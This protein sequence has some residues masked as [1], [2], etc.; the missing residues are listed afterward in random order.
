LVD[1]YTT[2]EVLDCLD[3]TKAA[4]V[5]SYGIEMLN[6]VVGMGGERWRILLETACAGVKSH[7]DADDL[8]A[9]RKLVANWRG[10]A[11]SAARS[12]MLIDHLGGEIAAGRKTLVFAGFPGASERLA[13]ALRDHFG[14]R[15]VTEFRTD[16]D[17]MAKEE[18]VRRFRV[19]PDVMVMVSDESGGEGRNFQFAHSL[20]HVD[21]PWQPAVIEQR[22][23]RLDRLGRESVSTDVV[24]HVCVS[25]GAWE[26]GLYACYHE[27]LDLF[28]TSVS[29]LE[30]SLRHLQ[31]Q[32]IDAALGGGQDALADLAPTLRSIA[33][34]ERVRDDSEALL[35]EA[36]YHAARAERFVRTPSADNET[37]LE[38]AFLE[39]FRGLAGGKGV[40]KFKGTH[41]SDGIWTL[42]P[43]EIR[44]G[45][46]SVVD[47]DAA[48]ELGKRVGTFRRAIAQRQRDIEFLTYGNPLFDAVVGALSQSLTGRSYAIACQA[49][50]FG[51]FIGI[52]LIIAA[53]PQ[54]Q[55]ADIS[56]SLINLAEAIFG[57]RRRP[58][59]IPLVV[60]APVDG[61]ALGALRS[62]LTTSG[63]GPRWRDLSGEE[64]D[65]MVRRHDGDL[66]ACLHRAETEVVP[67]ARATLAAELADPLGAEID[68]V[69]AQRQQLLTAG[70]ATALSEAAML[71]RYQALIE[72]WDI[73]IDGV[74][75]LAVN[76]RN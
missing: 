63:E 29:G 43:D 42:R 20:V 70:D 17:D 8:S 37:Q 22:I 34:G 74:G 21:L 47:R 12:S 46:I 62:S 18:N 60:D 19:E 39:Y 1:P 11:T 65:A 31:D 5:N 23:G 2:L 61:P 4:K 15:A 69:T 58:L 56:P 71:E 67:L 49:P 55:A 76:V 64:V 72:S 44:H 53:R 35:D 59:F 52:E 28:G 48:G 40:S 75:F 13:Q 30:F 9:A 16:L 32:I 7:V 73:V 36:S 24:S 27:G 50:G 26:A 25:S 38:T 45:E 6:G 10:S 68:R 3:G 54:I 41:G 57:T 66:S 33:D 14:D 51:E